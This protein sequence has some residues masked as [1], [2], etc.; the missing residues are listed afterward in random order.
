MEESMS[1]KSYF[2]SQN[3]IINSAKS[4]KDIKEEKDVREKYEN[5]DIKNNSNRERIVVNN[6]RLRFVNIFRTLFEK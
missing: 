5:I 2:V 1:A 6:E 4:I 3:K